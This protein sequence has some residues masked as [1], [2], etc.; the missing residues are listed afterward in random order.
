MS[1]GGR[2]RLWDPVSPCG[3]TIYFS[4]ICYPSHC[5][6]QN[7]VKNCGPFCGPS[8]VHS[9]PLAPLRASDKN[10]ETRTI[11][12][13]QLTSLNENGCP[14]DSRRLHHFFSLAD[15]KIKMLVDGLSVLSR[16][17]I[18]V[19]VYRSLLIYESIQV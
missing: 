16:E 19:N 6:P 14:G 18:A 7:Y 15:S 17:H 12:Q 4:E 11:K 8:Y 5:L 13:N 1:S 10:P 9:G 3:E 2:Y